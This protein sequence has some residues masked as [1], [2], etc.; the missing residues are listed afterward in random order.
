MSLYT[1]CE[2]LR[3]VLDCST[4][5][6]RT[7]YVAAENA[8]FPR[9]F[10]RILN[11][12]P[13]LQNEDTVFWKCFEKQTY[14][15]NISQAMQLRRPPCLALSWRRSSGRLLRRLACQVGV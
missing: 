4:F 9:P 2:P 14:S 10:S 1:A 7:K 12:T 15:A 13:H 8:I 6:I 5:G 3:I 11:P